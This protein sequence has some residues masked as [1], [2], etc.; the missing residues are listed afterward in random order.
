ML[1][2]GRTHA[3][4]SSPRASLRIG[5]V[6][7]A[8]AG[9][10]Y[11]DTSWIPACAGMTAGCVPKR[12]EAGWCSSPPSDELSSAGLCG[13]AR[14][15][16]PH[17]TSGSCLNAAAAGRV[18]SSA[19]PA[20]TEQRKAALAPRGP[21]RQGSLL[22]LLSCRHKLAKW[23]SAHFAKQSYADT[24]V[25]RLPGRTPGADGQARQKYQREAAPAAQGFD[26]SART[27]GGAQPSWIPAFAGMTPSP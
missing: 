17:L 20:K 7:P 11:G 26:T 21:R 12:S 10:Q 8:Q 19:R 27:G 14:S 6:I 1:R 22:C 5:S 3:A 24:K 16:H 4:I 18:V 2:T 13:S 15:A 23:G 25:G 9:I